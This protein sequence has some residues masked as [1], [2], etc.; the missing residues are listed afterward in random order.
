MQEKEAKERAKT[1][2]NLYLLTIVVLLIALLIAL[3]LAYSVRKKLRYLL[4]ETLHE[5]NIPLSTILAN[6]IR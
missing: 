2:S 6:T 5:V 4:D 1:E 3:Y